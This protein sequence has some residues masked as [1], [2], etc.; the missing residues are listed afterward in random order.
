MRPS[1]KEMSSGT[2]GMEYLTQ[3]GA[4]QLTTGQDKRCTSCPARPM[5]LAPLSLSQSLGENEMDEAVQQ[6]QQLPFFTGSIDLGRLSF[7]QEVVYDYLLGVLAAD[8]FSSNPR[9]VVRLLGAVPFSPDSVTVH[10][11]REHVQA[12]NGLVVSERRSAGA[13]LAPAAPGLGRTCS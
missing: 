13:R 4:P 11:T 7:S 5:E 1:L 2:C 6:I 9:K 8:S 10:V 12:I 3:P